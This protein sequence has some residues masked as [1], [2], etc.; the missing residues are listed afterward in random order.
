MVINDRSE[1]AFPTKEIDCHAGGLSSLQVARP[2]GT[3]V[4]R[5]LNSGRRKGLGPKRGAGGSSGGGGG[6]RDGGGGGGDGGG[7]ES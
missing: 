5:R 7:G 3:R 1:G 2:V 6:S 4:R